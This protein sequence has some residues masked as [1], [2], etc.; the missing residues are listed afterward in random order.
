MFKAKKEEIEAEKNL[1]KNEEVLQERLLKDKRNGEK[2][3]K[4]SIFRQT[5]SRKKLRNIRSLL[6]I[7]RGLSLRNNIIKLTGML[8]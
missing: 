6:E 5:I 2:R 4:I 8:L 1:I 7:L 3:S